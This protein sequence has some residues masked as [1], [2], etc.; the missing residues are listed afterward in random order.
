M[1]LQLSPDPEPEVALPVAVQR[2]AASSASVRA[3]MQKQKRRDTDPEIQVRKR[4]HAAGI[5]YRV[6]N[7]LEADLRTRATSSGEV[8]VLQCSSTGVIGTAAR[9]MSLDRR[10]TPTGGHASWTATSREIGGPIP[11]LLPEGGRFCVTG[12]TT[13]QPLLQA[14][15]WWRSGAAVRLLGDECFRQQRSDRPAEWNR[16]RVTDLSRDLRFAAHPLVFLWEALQQRRLIVRYRAIFDRVSIAALFGL[17]ELSSYGRRWA[18][19]VHSTHNVPRT[20]VMFSPARCQ[21]CVRDIEAISASRNVQETTQRQ[22]RVVA[23]Q[24]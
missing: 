19:P 6:D 14:Q 11:S 9:Y 20:T 18:I 23:R 10:P 8:C 2:P 24:V 5:R 16:N 17:K 1:T 15:S 4:L 7:K 13:R 22:R 12:S 21:E 3:R